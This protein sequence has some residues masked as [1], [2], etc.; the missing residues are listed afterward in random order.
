MRQKAPVKRGLVREGAEDGSSCPHESIIGDKCV[1]NCR[2]CGIFFPKVSLK[3]SQSG[4]QASQTGV[5]T[6]RNEKESFQCC[7]PMTEILRTTY[8]ECMNNV[9]I[10]VNMQYV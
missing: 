5:K 9:P 2:Q 6:I 8:A 10:S 1:A 7:F 3:A 4:L